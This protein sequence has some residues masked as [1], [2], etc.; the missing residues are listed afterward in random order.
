[1]AKPA[2]LPQWDETDVNSTEPDATH[3][4]QGWLAPGS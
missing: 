3:K 1:M 4:A 2:A